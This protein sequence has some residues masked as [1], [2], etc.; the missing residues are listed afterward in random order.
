M[1]IKVSKKKDKGGAYP[2]YI[3]A[4]KNHHL[5]VDLSYNALVV[6]GEKIILCREVRI[7]EIN[8]EE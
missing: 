8:D 2:V 6:Q 1:T 3:H 4:D 7:V 5:S